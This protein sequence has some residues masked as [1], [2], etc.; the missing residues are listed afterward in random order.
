MFVLLM[1]NLLIYDLSIESMCQVFS[2][3]NS[4]PAIIILAYNNSLNAPLEPVIVSKQTCFNKTSN[5]VKP[6]HNI[7]LIAFYKLYTTSHM[8]VQSD[9][10]HTILSTQVG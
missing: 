5:Q 10:L 8:Q 6:G 1:L 3:L 4:D 7:Q 2:S 9:T